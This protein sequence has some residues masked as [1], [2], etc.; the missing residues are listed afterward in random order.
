MRLRPF[1]LEILCA[2]ERAAA[3]PSVGTHQTLTVLPRAVCFQEI[4]GEVIGPV[5]DIRVTCMRSFPSK[6]KLIASIG[7]ALEV[8]ES[9]HYVRRSYASLSYQL[10]DEGAQAISTPRTVSS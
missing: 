2:I 1:D 4:L 7:S 3:R 5:K 9:A 6:E 8:M 10:T